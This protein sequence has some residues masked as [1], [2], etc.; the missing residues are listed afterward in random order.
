LY[1]ATIMRISSS[2]SRKRMC[3][4][5]PISESRFVS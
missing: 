5:L 3:A 1:L 2:F 4:V